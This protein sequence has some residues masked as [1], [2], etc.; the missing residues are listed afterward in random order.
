MR[1]AF[2]LLL[3]TIF[4]VGF[5]QIPKHEHTLD[6]KEA[7]TLETY[8]VRGYPHTSLSPIFGSLVCSGQMA[9]SLLQYVPV[10]EL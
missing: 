3:S 1:V 9:L 2:L 8:F 7:F 10:W 5:E 4:T 6:F